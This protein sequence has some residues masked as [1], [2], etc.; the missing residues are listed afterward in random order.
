M[1]K[2]K[3]KVYRKEFKLEAVRLVMEKGVSGA[4][5]AREVSLKL[6]GYKADT[7]RQP[8]FTTTVPLRPLIRPRLFSKSPFT[9]S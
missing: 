6:A 8:H 7:S 9:S 3:R 2:K 1:S 4:D 5:V